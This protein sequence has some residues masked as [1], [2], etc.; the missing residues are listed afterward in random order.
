MF[1]LNLFGMKTRGWASVYNGVACTPSDVTVF[2]A[3][4]AIYLGTAGDVVVKYAGGGIVT[5]KNLVAGVNHS[6]QIVQVLATGTTAL[7]IVLKY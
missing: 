2:D 4:R 3:T 1:N 6:E 7:N 5:L